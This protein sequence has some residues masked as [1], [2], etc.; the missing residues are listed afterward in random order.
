MD[1]SDA[2]NIKTTADRK[3]YDTLV[4]KHALGCPNPDTQSDIKNIQTVISTLTSKI[5]AFQ[6]SLR[7]ADIAA[8]LPILENNKDIDKA[9][10]DAS[11]EMAKYMK[12]TMNKLQQFTT[13]EFNEKLASME[14]LAPPSHTLELLNKKV[15]GLEKI[16]CMF[17]GMAG[18][19]LSGLIAAALKKAFNRK[20]K[21]AEEAAANTA[22]SE[23]GV[24]G[25]STSAVIP[26]VP[27]LDTP[28]SNDVPPP[29]ADGFYRPTPLCET[30]EIIGEVLGGTINTIMSGFDSAIGPVID[31]ISNSLGGSSTETGSENEGTIDSAINE[32]NVLSSLSSGDLILSFSQTLADQAGIDPNKVGGANRYWADGNYGRGLLGFIDAAGQDTLDNQQ[33]IAQALELI[34]D[35]SNPT[36]IAAGMVLASNLLGVNENL[37]TGIGNAFQAIRIGDIPSLISA[38]GSLAAINPRVLNAIAGKGASLA[39]MI[40]SGLGLGALGGM[41]FD[42]TTALNF[43]NS[44]TK[45]F[46]CDPDPECSPNDEHTMQSGGGSAGKPSTSSVAESARNTSESVGERRS[47]G[48]R[49]E[50]LSSSKQGVK[51]KTVFAKPKSRTKDLTN[52][53]GYVNGQPYYGDFHVHER[54]DGSIVKMVGIAHTTTPHSIIYDTV[55]ESL[56]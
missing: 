37:L 22:V 39:G 36:G 3:K 30:E 15:E 18:L 21:K 43:V 42:I 56:Q 10:E 28:G 6:K 40:P 8:G 5:E 38:A 54:E 20:K 25:V 47:Y 44:I 35:R 48:T 34:D 2:N 23:A 50:K 16:A 41:N 49:I 11:K 53:V 13:K 29:T 24:A 33:L 19:A 27:V 55:Q 32:N 12:G 7:D 51:I 45:I 9:I 26:S 46:D 52:L 17:N 14:N 31:E 4:E 1:S